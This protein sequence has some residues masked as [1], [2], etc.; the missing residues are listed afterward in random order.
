M[1]KSGVTLLILGIVSG[2]VVFILGD[3]PLALLPLT[4]F[5]LG[6]AIGSLVKSPDGGVG[7]ISVLVG[8]IVLLIGVAYMPLMS[9]GIAIIALGLI[10]ATRA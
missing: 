10:M 7:M 6:S 3:E 1:K 9:V 5:L 4:G 8:L 2:A